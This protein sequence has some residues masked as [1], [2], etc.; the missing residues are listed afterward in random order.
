MQRVTVSLDENETAAFDAIVVEQGYASRSE[1]IRDL[2][3]RA[4][5]TRRLNATVDGSCVANLSYVYDHHRATLSRRL[6]ELQHAHHDLVVATTHVHLDHD[7]CLEST[8]LKG[9]VAA[10][11]A[12]ADAIEATNGV[13]YTT[14]NLISDSG[15]AGHPHDSM[16]S[17]NH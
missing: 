7:N 16:P 9:T 14:L 15:S 11:R 2:V 6:T 17:H 12:L 4:V 13:R 10:V 1:A 3:R 8:M 5:D